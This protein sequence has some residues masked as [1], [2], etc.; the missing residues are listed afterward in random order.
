MGRKRKK[1]REVVVISGAFD[2]IHVGHIRLIKESSKYGK[3]VII[4]NSD[5]WLMKKK[6]YFFM[7][8][9]ERKELLE[10]MRHVYSVIPSNDRSNDVCEELQNLN[11]RY[12]AN[13]GERNADNTPETDLCKELGIETLWDI[14]G[15]K[16]QSSSKLINDLKKRKIGKTEME[17]F[18][19][20]IENFH[21]A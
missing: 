18:K 11:P 21:G 17:R 15:S 13:G 16:I 20:I 2:P 1:K 19:E 10:N 8:Y 14:G 6:G 12:F 7:S 4:L 9:D 5:M 3:V